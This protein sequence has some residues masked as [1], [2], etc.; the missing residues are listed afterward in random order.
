MIKGESSKAAL[1]V[2]FVIAIAAAFW[3][4]LLAPR[5]DKVNE[6]KSE[7]TSLTTELSS[8][9][10]RATEAKAAKKHFATDY[11]QLL[12]LG[13]A[14]PADSSTSSLLLELDALGISTKTGFLNISSGS[15]SEGSEESTEGEGAAAGL[16]PL[17]ATAGPSGLLR[18][19][20]ALDYSGGFFQI[21]DFIEGL[22]SLVQTKNEEVKADGRLI[23][24][25]GFE[26]A[27]G[28]EGTRSASDLLAAHFSVSTY[29]T[30][31]GQGLTAGASPA[32]PESAGYEE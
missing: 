27:P 19:P 32:G 31:P 25:D 11:N 9:E 26:L 8:A 24:I 23:T 2:L 13:K 6:L 21:A 16:P 3:L 20:Y 14:V 1:S 12:Q 10:A 7:A 28:G 5:Q 30:P 4:V 18:M 17:G 15:E 29:V 22:N